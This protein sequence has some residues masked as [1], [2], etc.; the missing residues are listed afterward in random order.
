[1]NPRRDFLR[2]SAATAAGLALAGGRLHGDDSTSRAGSEANRA[3][4][5]V[6]GAGVGSAVGLG[7][8]ARLIAAVE[9]GDEATVGAILAADPAL[10]TI[11]DARGRSLAWIAAEAGHAKLFPLLR[12]TSAN[13]EIF[14]SAV[15]ADTAGIAKLQQ[16][17]AT[18]VSRVNR[19]GWTPLLA[20][21]VCGQGASVESLVGI[22]AELEAKSPTGE[23]ALQLALQHR[24][25][26]AVEWMTQIL[27]GNGGDHAVRLP[28]GAAP[29]HQAARRGHAPTV[30]LLLRKG[31][32]P[33]A[34]DA[35]GKTASEIA[36]PS[37]AELLR[38]ATQQ[39]R[40]N[41]ELAGRLD[42]KAGGSFVVT[43]PPGIPQTMINRFISVAHAN[44][45]ETKRMVQLCPALLNTRATWD[46]LAIEGPAHLGFE[47]I[48][49]Y[50]LDAGA[51]CSLCTAVMLGET[52]V[53]QRH[54]AASSRA[55][56]A[57]GPHDLAVLFYVAYGR[58]KPDLAALLLD[59][60]A[61]VNVNIRGRGVLH[62]A[63]TRGH[64]ELLEFL[65]SRGADVNQR[66]ISSFMPGT[67]LAVALRRKQTRAAEFLRSR[68]AVE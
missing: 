1:M 22:G 36:V 23:T 52:E 57:K 39:S 4:G 54:L 29:L 55:A 51:P 35:A 67:P 50:L 37:V 26:A 46:E 30:R 6:A 10:R 21:S 47:P 60:G 64:V 13:P 63:A 65:I 2:L 33:A 24:D 34:K 49:R 20:S 41:G 11:E 66:S 28:D 38:G 14:E 42:L 9:R 15:T 17:D 32:D 16:A 19:H 3:P 45:E 40:D 62:E 53:V 18:S 8:G 58:P 43:N 48:V 61:D 25:D 59:H 27:L 5:D 31:A 44:L 7:A 12:G 68:G 56:H